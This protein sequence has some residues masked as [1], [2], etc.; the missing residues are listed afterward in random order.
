MIKLYNPAFTCHERRIPEIPAR[1]HPVGEN[2]FT[3]TKYSEMTGA[4]VISHRGNLDTKLSLLK[5]VRK[6]GVARLVCIIS[7]QGGIEQKILL[8][9]KTRKCQGAATTQ[10][11]NFLTSQLL[12]QKRP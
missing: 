1:M 11:L 3:F 8:R 2:F 5:N 6:S 4:A 9:K 10:L 7:H 12:N